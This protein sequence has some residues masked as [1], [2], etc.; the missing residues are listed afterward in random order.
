MLIEQYSTN[1]LA[2]ALISNFT[3][4]LRITFQF[5][6]VLQEKMFLIAISLVLP[7]FHRFHQIFVTVSQDEKKKLFWK[8]FS[9][10]TFI[11]LR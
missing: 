1:L 5:Y 2:I 6:W 3:I 8:L 11:Y 9:L 4:S 7:C 10:G